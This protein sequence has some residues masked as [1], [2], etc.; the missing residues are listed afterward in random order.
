ME[1]PS[2]TQ[3]QFLKENQLKREASNRFFIP[4]FLLYPLIWSQKTIFGMKLP[5]SFL[6]LMVIG[7]MVSYCYLILKGYHTIQIKRDKI[8]VLGM[9]VMVM[10]ILRIIGKLF[11]DN[12]LGSIHVD[13]EII[14][15][16]LVGMYFL[17]FQHI[18]FY[19]YYL[20]LLL[21]SGLLFIMCYFLNLLLGADNMPFTLPTGETDLESYMLLFSSISVLQYC[22]CKDKIRSVFYLSISLIGFFVIFLEGKVMG[23]IL[24]GVIFFIIPVVL[25]PVGIIIKR[26]AVV[27]LLY[28]FLLS[29]M[30]IFIEYLH[31]E[32][33]A[34]IY[35]LEVSI[36]IDL[37]MAIVCVI[38]LHYWERLPKDIKVEK[39]RFPEVTSICKKVLGVSGIV[40]VLLV[41]EGDLWAQ[42]PDGIGMEI[43]KMLSHSLVMELSL[44]NNLLYT[45]IVQHGILG[46][47]I[48][49]SF[50]LLLAWKIMKLGRTVIWE[51]PYRGLFVLIGAMLGIQA[52]LW[53]PGIHIV[54]IYFVFL[55]LALNYQRDDYYEIRVNSIIKGVPNEKK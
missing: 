20:D 39:T 7:I 6:F 43:I 4:F 28:F 26:C 34:P 44:S 29:S 13:S 51:D 35:N 50:L 17:L 15:L 37:I 48:L 52:L 22:I 55:L 36:Y 53:S 30:P 1:P 25:E 11:Q 47:M 27:C 38:V 8:V 46:C 3:L 24:M 41:I 45:G 21:Y 33:I 16:L 49:V 2:K 5:V 12:T 10:E 9:A 14:I 31:L 18:K 23:I 19:N 32:Q 42:L 54:S 40:F